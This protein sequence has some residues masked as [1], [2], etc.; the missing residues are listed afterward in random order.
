MVCED[1]TTV[2]QAHT[3]AVVDTFW[4]KVGLPCCQAGLAL[5]LAGTA[6]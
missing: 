4:H 1:L 3:M 6:L 2:R 5:L